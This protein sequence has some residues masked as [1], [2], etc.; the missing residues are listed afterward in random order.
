MKTNVEMFSEKGNQLY[1]GLDVHKNQWSV[2][3]RTEEFEH[4]TFTQPPNPEILYD[5]IQKNF[6]RYQVH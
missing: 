5:Y 2:C 4:K 1:V 6:S 3:M